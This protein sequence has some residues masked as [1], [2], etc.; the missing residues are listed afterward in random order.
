MK[1]LDF[2]LAKAAIGDAGRLDAGAH[3]D[4]ARRARGSF[5]EP[6]PYMS[7]EQARGQ[8][9]DK[10]TDVWAFGCVLYEMLTGRM[11][12]GGATLSDMIA[13]VIERE[14][15]WQALPSSTP[16]AI[17]KLLRRCLTKPVGRRLRDIGD[18]VLDL[19]S[20]SAADDSVRTAGLSDGSE[21]V[22]RAIGSD[23]Y[24][25]GSHCDGCDRRQQRVVDGHSRVRAR[26]G[27]HDAPDVRFGSHDRTD[28]Q[29]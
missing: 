2:G 26:A 5:S 23:R 13:A 22:P 19:E 24:G 18:A 17:H 15:D 12:F 27:I 7:P 14:P 21:A 3:D 29:R 4:W 9:V 6:Q 20:A 8:A 11:A 1:V 28:H 16:A 25:G 10:R